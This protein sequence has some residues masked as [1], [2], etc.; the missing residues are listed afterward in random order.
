MAFLLR[1]YHYRIAYERAS[2][3]SSRGRRAGIG[4][5]IFRDLRPFAALKSDRPQAHLRN[6]CQIFLAD[7][8][9][10]Y[11]EY[12][13]PA[14][15]TLLLR[16]KGLSSRLIWALLR[17]L[18]VVIFRRQTILGRLFGWLFAGRQKLIAGVSNGDEMLWLR[19]VFLEHLS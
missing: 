17:R 1:W 10:T 4:S 19:F 16:N 5:I 9:H 3:E 18:L 12:E 11:V 14:C 13:A 2:T 6:T 15:P 7:C 8:A